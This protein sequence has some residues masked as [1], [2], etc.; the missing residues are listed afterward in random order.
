VL[1]LTAEYLS[2]EY[3]LLPAMYWLH[4]KSAALSKA[5]ISPAGHVPG[6]FP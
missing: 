5:E 3:A 6:L 4:K 1:R 2:E